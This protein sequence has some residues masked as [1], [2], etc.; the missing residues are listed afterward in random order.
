M[1]VRLDDDLYRVDRT[2]LGPR[3]KPLPVRATYTQ[4]GLF[5]VVLVVSA[6]GLR[7]L[8]VSLGPTFELLLT[9][10]AVWVLACWGAAWYLRRF[11]SS[12]RPLIDELM[13][14]GQELT[15][16]RP[17][18]PRTQRVRMVMTVQVWGPWVEPRPRRH[19]RLWWWVQRKADG[20]ARFGLRLVDPIRWRLVEPI[21][22][23]RR[24]AHPTEPSNHRTEPSN[25]WLIKP[26]GGPP[27][28]QAAEAPQ[29][30][31]WL[32][33]SSQ[34]PAKPVDLESDPAAEIDLVE[35]RA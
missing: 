28:T 19:L 17:A 30:N 21:R 2:Y 6:I 33:D 22:R 27:A 13:R 10:L 9:Q 23:R 4:W 16:R 14:I 5:F 15:A 34:L 7:V 8:R 26:T 29:Q 18:K 3:G 12:D 1:R 31:P 25:P 20:L 35:E 24:L 32:T 11:T